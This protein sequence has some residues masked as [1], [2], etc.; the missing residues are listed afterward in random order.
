MLRGGKPTLQSLNFNSIFE[1]SQLKSHTMT[2]N[3]DRYLDF[4]ARTQAGYRAPSLVITES[5]LR[6]RSFSPYTIL[7]IA[8][9]IILIVIL[10]AILAGGL[11]LRPRALPLRGS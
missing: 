5:G 11:G 8:L 6:R 3:R 7:L 1:S 4:Q 10:V 2:T 9:V